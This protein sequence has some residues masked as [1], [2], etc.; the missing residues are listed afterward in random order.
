[1]LRQTLTARKLEPKGS[2]LLPK[3]KRKE[4]GG[5]MRNENL[6][7]WDRQ[8]NESNKAYEAFCIFRDLGES[9]SLQKVCVECAKSRNLI[10]RWANN[11]NWQSRADAWDASI[12]EEARKRAAKDKAK[13]IERQIQIGQ[14]LQSKAANAINNKNLEEAS[15][16][17]LGQLIELGAKLERTARE[18]ETIEN[19]GEKS[20][21]ITFTFDRGGANV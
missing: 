19:A 4:R 5:T 2:F 11:F 12:T 15:I 3:L 16:N 8:E 14:M 13:M 9:R 21:N 10:S 7:P 17:A 20:D 1:M 6:K 18:I